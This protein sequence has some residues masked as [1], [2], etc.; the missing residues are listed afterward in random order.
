MEKITLEKLAIM[1]QK[2]FEGVTQNMDERFNIVDE[3]F[4]AVDERFNAVDGRFNIVEQRL[5][6]IEQKLDNVVYQVEF[7]ELKSRVE[8]LEKK[9]QKI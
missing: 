5:G 9:L 3:R 8:F 7:L 4:N 1:V 6:K 2:G